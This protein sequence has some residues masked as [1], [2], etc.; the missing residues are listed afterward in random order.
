MASFVFNWQGYIRVTITSQDQRGPSCMISSSLRVLLLSIFPVVSSTMAVFAGGFAVPQQTA[1]AAALSNAL[2]AGIDD[3]SA[4]YI[5]PA[6]LAFV[7]GNQIL[8]NL[9][10]V[11]A[12]SSV[13]NSGQTSKNHKDDNFIPTLFANYHIPGTN[14]TAGVGTYTPFGLATSYG[15]TEFTRFAS[16]DSEL[17]LFY[18]SPT[19]SW[20][21]VSYLSVGG[22]LSFV[23]SSEVLSRAL[24]LGAVGVGE[25]RLRITDTDD[26][27]GYHLGIL[28][29][30]FSN[31]KFGLTY[32]S[33]V[34][35]NFDQ[36]DVKFTD[37]AFTGG[38]TT[39]VR[40][41]GIHLPIP[42]VIS[43]GIHWQI[44][45]EWGAEFV[46]DFTRWSEFEQLKVNFST[47]LPALG[48]DF[49]LRAYLFLKTG[50]IQV[51]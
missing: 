44:N 12:I 32:R 8:G 26:A 39:T 11:N 41:K 1:K 37:A 50:K 4:V 9:I 7:E 47:P 25:G 35:L 36:A 46:Y 5:N 28:L 38:A 10:Y 15:K 14:L 6:G 43:A 19:V 29:G 48:G 42:P 31:I 13:K 20:Q 27:L 3:P 33:R 23:H 34:D 16:I 24:F 30:P 40:G 45:P 18:I 17:K 21:P 51:R 2:T 49:Q 22:G